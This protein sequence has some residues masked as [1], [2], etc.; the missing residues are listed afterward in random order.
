MCYDLVF[1]NRFEIFI[2]KDLFGGWIIIVGF[3]AVL[4]TLNQ[5]RESNQALC[6]DFPTTRLLYSSLKDIYCLVKER[7]HQCVRCRL[8]G[9]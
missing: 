9:N 1:P 6:R 5:C 8:K 2:K 4:A 3:Y 7:A